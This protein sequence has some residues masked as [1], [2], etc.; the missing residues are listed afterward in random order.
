MAETALVMPLVSLLIMVMVTLAMSSWTATSAN[1]IAQ[2]AARAGSVVQGGPGERSATAIH[3]AQ[4]LAGQFGYGEYAIE[5]LNPGA[6]PGDQIVVR[7]SWA[8]PNW[9][10]NAV[11]LFPGL[12]GD[13]ITGEAVAAYRVEGW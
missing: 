2:R 6:G 1:T 7:V 4:E 3:T 8:A 13:A 12:F 9:A 11:P 5:I 10:A